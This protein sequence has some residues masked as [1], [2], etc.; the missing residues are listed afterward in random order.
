MYLITPL[1][2]LKYLTIDEDRLKGSSLVTNHR[3]KLLF[4]AGAGEFGGTYYLLFKNAGKLGGGEIL[5]HTLD[6]REAGGG[7][8]RERKDTLPWKIGSN[9]SRGLLKSRLRIVKIGR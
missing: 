6:E 3:D 1:H 4:R 2:G 8:E 9:T 7:R 5:Q